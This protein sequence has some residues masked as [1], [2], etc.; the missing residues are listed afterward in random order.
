[1]RETMPL[2]LDWLIVMVSSGAGGA[3]VTSAVC[4]AQDH[5]QQQCVTHKQPPQLN[6]TQT[7]LGKRH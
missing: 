7:R 6:E 2:P 5:A 1:M 3:L 4:D